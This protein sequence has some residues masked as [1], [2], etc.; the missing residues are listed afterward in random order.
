LGATTGATTYPIT[1]EKVVLVVATTI[2]GPSTVNLPAYD[3]AY[4][5]LVF[6]FTVGTTNTQT[7]N[8]TAGGSTISGIGVAAAVTT[9]AQFNVFYIGGAVRGYKIVSA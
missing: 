7:F 9:T 1:D 4:E 8:I 2:T 6:Q 5:G 3:A